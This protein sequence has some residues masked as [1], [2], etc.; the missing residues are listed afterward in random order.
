MP[1]LETI[2]V[3]QLVLAVSLLGLWAFAGQWP[4]LLTMAV[5]G[6]VAALMNLLPGIRNNRLLHFTVIIAIVGVAQ[7]LER[8]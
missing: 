3:I 7:L 1:S 6:F 5:V 4:F 2:V 8:R